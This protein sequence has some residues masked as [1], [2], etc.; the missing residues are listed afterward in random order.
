MRYRDAASA[1]KVNASCNVLSAGASGAYAL[2][3]L[4]RFG[5]IDTSVVDRTVFTSLPGIAPY[6]AQV[7]AAW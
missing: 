4:V 6:A 1:A 7:A 2:V 3:Q 5:W